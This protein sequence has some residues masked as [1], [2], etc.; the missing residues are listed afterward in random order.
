MYPWYKGYVGDIQ[1]HSDDVDG[2]QELYG[3]CGNDDTM[4]RQ[5][6]LQTLVVDI[7]AHEVPRSPISLIVD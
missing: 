6:W 2:I 4:K 5:D 3:E 1:L 7:R